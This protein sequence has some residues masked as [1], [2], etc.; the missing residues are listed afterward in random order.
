MT[1]ACCNSKVPALVVFL[2]APAV[3]AEDPLEMRKLKREN[4]GECHA[5]LL[6]HLLPAV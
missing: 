1:D 4:V 3:A 6:M 5:V 2:V